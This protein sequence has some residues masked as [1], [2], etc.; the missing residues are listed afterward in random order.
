MEH[1]EFKRTS[2]FNGK[3]KEEIIGCKIRGVR[4]Q[5]NTVS[6]FENPSADDGT[7]VVKIEG[8]DYQVPEEQILT[9]LSHY[10]EFVSGL[11]EDQFKDNEVTGGNNRTGNYSVIMKLEHKI[12]QL[13]PMNGRRVKIYHKGIDKLCTRCFAGHRKSECKSESKVDWIEYVRHF[14]TTHDFIPIELYGRWN[15]LVNNADKRGAGGR[16]QP[17]DTRQST[18]MEPLIG[19]KENGNAEKEENPIT[20]SSQPP[21]TD[22]FNHPGPEPT[23]DQFDIPMTDE[24]Y[25]RMVDRFATVGLQRW[26]VDKSIEAKTTAYNKACREHKKL[27]T[28]YKK[29]AD[30]NKAG[31]NTR[32][33]SLK[34]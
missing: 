27:M 18:D 29:K 9:W 28:E 23:K 12:P 25:E 7:T 19:R 1:F 22:E 31:K 5:P 11:E 30:S 2:T 15:E 3:I 17:P 13:I 4:W 8:C 34:Q 32:K 24:A 20:P 26:E 33:N 10:G 6:A 21:K 14:M 16:K